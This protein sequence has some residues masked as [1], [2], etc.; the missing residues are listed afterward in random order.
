M[1]RS[2]RSAVLY[3]GSLQPCDGADG[4]QGP[5]P[6]PVAASALEEQ[7]EVRAPGQAAPEASHRQAGAAAVDDAGISGADHRELS[8]TVRAER[9][10]NDGG[11]RDGLRTWK[12]DAAW[13]SR[14]YFIPMHPHR[15]QGRNVLIVD[16]DEDILSSFDLAM[17]AEGASTARAVDGNTAVSAWHAGNPD[18]VVLDMMLPKRSG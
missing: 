15:L 17:R 4:P 10:I 8:C 1:G 16:D 11:F 12:K 9:V 5:G 13:S 18:A 7:A 2:A 14:L 6:I 3:H